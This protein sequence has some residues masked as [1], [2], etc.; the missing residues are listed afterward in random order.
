VNRG[1]QTD[2]KLEVVVIPVSDVDRD[3]HFYEAWGGG[4]TCHCARGGRAMR[5]IESERM[6]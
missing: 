3:K 1:A 5:L 2:L 6:E 4:Q